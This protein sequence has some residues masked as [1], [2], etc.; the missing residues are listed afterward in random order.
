MFFLGSRATLIGGIGFKVSPSTLIV[1][2]GLYV[3]GRAPGWF[4]AIFLN[5][6][7]EI[8]IADAGVSVLGSAAGSTGP[9]I[10]CF[11]QAAV[12]R[13]MAIGRIS[14]FITVRFNG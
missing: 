2:A 11:V 8:R 12:K 3:L 1:E 9:G 7:P 4:G 10:S 5:V 14:G 6:S 13:S